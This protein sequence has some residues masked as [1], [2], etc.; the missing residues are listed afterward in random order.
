MSCVWTI[1]RQLEERSGS[2]GAE[3]KTAQ[4]VLQEAQQSVCVFLLADHPLTYPYF[5]LL[6][7]SCLSVSQTVGDVCVCQ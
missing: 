1:Q 7:S 3:R 5:V 6:L 2:A 4:L